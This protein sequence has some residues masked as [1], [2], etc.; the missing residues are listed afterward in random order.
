MYKS[1]LL[2]TSAEARLL[3]QVK[4]IDYPPPGV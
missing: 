1:T 2:S 4:K 3:L